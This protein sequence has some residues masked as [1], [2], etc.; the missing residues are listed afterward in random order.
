MNSFEDEELNPGFVGI[1]FKK[2]GFGISGPE[3]DTHESPLI[4]EVSLL[5]SSIRVASSL[6]TTTAAAT[7][8]TFFSPTELVSSAALSNGVIHIGSLP[9]DDEHVFVAGLDTDPLDCTS[10]P[11]S[12]MGEVPIEEELDWELVVLLVQSFEM[13]SFG[14]IRPS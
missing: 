9:L 6:S 7:A 5:M 3:L 11:A 1:L 10:I 4:D 2:F 12:I 8:V 14:V 13:N